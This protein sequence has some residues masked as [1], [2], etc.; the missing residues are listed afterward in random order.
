MLK[1][2]L[3]KLFYDNQ[4]TR[5]AF[6][7]FQLEVLNDMALDSV[8]KQRGENAQA[9]AEA[10]TLVEKSFKRLADEYQEKRGQVIKDQNV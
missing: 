6:K 4:P 8:F 5:D 7:E 3:L 2:D 10:K 1:Q 9:I